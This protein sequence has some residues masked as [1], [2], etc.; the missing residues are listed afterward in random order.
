M[1][2]MVCVPILATVAEVEVREESDN[3]SWMSDIFGTVSLLVMSCGAVQE[4]PQLKEMVKI[5]GPHLAPT[6]SFLRWR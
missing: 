4:D 5:L 6:V 3:L 2:L 1:S